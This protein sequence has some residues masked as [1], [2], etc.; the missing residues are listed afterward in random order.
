MATI[1]PFHRVTKN[2]PTALPARV[3]DLE[4]ELAAILAAAELAFDRVCRGRQDIA[5]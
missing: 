2:T 4:V 5:A 3:T 1:C